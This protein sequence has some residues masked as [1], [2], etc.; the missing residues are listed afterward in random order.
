MLMIMMLTVMIPSRIY[1][2]S[3]M[4]LVAKLRASSNMFPT[5]LVSVCILSSLQRWRLISIFYI[6]LISASSAEE[7]QVPRPNIVT[8]EWSSQVIRFGRRNYDVRSGY[9]TPHMLWFNETRIRK[10][11]FVLMHLHVLKYCT[12]Y[13]L[14]INVTTLTTGSRVCNMYS[15][16]FL[17]NIYYSRAK[18]WDVFILSGYEVHNISEAG[19]ASVFRAKWEIEEPNVVGPLERGSLKP[20]V[21]DYQSWTTV[22]VQNVNDIYEHIIV[23]IL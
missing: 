9:R 23:G 4:K 15:Y 12:F 17:K 20:C 3:K 21:V 14:I 13:R 16:K 10:F 19:L 5:G 8:R 6:S 1:S 18:I 7:R 22:K 11:T 2:L